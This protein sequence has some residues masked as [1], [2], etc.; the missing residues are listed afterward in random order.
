MIFDLK[1]K[2]LFLLP[3]W[4]L[5]S[6][7]DFPNSPEREWKY[8]QQGAYS[9]A[10][11]PKGD[12]VL[13]GSIHHGA[14]LWDSR[15]FQRLYNWNHTQSEFSQIAHA[16][17]SEDGRYA[18]TADNRTIVLW[19]LTTG[20]AVWQWYAPA[21]LTEMV[22]S[23]TGRYA[24]L[25][26]EDNTAVMF[27]IQNGGV[28][29]TFQHAGEVTT[30]DLSP[31]GLVAA[32]GS[33]DLTVKMW[34]VSNG[35][36][37]HELKFDNFLREVKFSNSGRL[38]F[39]A[40]ARENS[41]IVDVKSGQQLSELKTYRYQVITS[42]FLPNDRQ[43]LLGMTNRR[44]ELRDTRSGKLL[45]SWQLP[46]TGKNQYSSTSVLAVSPAGKNFLAMSSGGYLFL[47]KR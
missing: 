22:L 21:D 42:R 41:R 29:R 40:A 47:L 13:I 4:V 2:Y 28:V 38:L 32:S 14:S 33:D 27:D 25:A 31:N 8:A 34:N 30:T 17:F 45:K 46:R 9:A 43:I 44:V 19:S 39:A 7:C 10:I 3:L 5:I 35:K 20:Q 1:L 23:K 6:A 12:K 18:A 26:M 36:Q 24:L 37:L 11:S 16:A 15:R